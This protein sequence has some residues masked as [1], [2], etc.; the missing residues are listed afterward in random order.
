MQ[1]FKNCLLFILLTLSGH[2][3]NSRDFLETPHHGHKLFSTW[4]LPPPF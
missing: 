2:S 4:G 3:I 1:D